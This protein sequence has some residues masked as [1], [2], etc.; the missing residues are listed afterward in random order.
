V[1]LVWDGRRFLAAWSSGAR[2]TV[3]ELPLDG[4]PATIVAT[5]RPRIVHGSVHMA[6]V[7]GG[8]ALTWR[9]SGVQDVLP[10]TRVATLRHDNSVSSSVTFDHGVRNFRQPRVVALPNGGIGHL[11]TVAQFAPPHHGSTRVVMRVAGAVLPTKPEPPRLTGEVRNGRVELAW[12]APPQEIAG[13]RIEYRIGDG[14]WNE[15]DRWFDWNDDEI[16]VEWQLR[17]GVAYRFRIRAF[18][19]AGTSDYSAPVVLNL[20]KRRSVR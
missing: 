1:E 15:L 19:D 10:H 14:A 18:S 20:P 3:A 9:E 6:A 4:G 13:Y 12:T 2:I 11:A 8:V 17:K 16:A 7:E 5:F